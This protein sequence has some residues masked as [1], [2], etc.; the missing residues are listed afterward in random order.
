MLNVCWMRDKYTLKPGNVSLGTA[1]FAFESIL[2][3]IELRRLL[4][5]IAI[6]CGLNYQ[7]YNLPLH[8]ESAFV[9]G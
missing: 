8:L 6:L 9:N 1:R 7:S 5:W 2:W 4:S 3:I